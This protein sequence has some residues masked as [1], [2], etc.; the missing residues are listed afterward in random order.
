MIW[1]T[2]VRHR[3]ISPD[4]IPFVLRMMVHCYDYLCALPE[5]REFDEDSLV[6]LTN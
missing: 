6:L 4:D 5:T 3:R 2:D 1:E